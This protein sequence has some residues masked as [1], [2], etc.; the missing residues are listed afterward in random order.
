[1]TDVSTILAKLGEFDFTAIVDVS[2]SM[3]EPVKG[4][5]G[6][7]RW[8]SMQESVTGF[9]RDIS[10]IDADGIDI[11]E[12]GGQLRTFRNVNTTKLTELFT[13]LKPRG[14]TPLAEALLNAF[15]L[16]KETSKKRIHVVWTDGVP[17]DAE[18]VKRAIIEQANSQSADDQCTVLFIQVGHDAGATAYLKSLDDDLKGAKYDIVDAKTITEVD[19]FPSTAELVYAAITG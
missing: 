5:S 6:T 17:N 3:A 13:E 8:A 18:A 2:S 10:D 15:K 12:L 1:M 14:G 11:I 4:A 9:V 19:A 7:S 16:G